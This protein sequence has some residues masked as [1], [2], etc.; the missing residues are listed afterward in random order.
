MRTKKGIV[1]SAKMNRTVAVAVTRYVVHPKYRKRYPVTKKFLADTGDLEV[2]E[3]DEVLIGETRPLS[4]RK[5]F[6][7][8]QILRSTGTGTV[9][10]EEELAAAR[11]Q[12]ESQP[13]PQPQ[14]QPA[15]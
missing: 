11:D 1:T 9:S 8:L 15:P 5:C 6:K 4:K 12:S 7:V 2:K 13:Q 3:G 10:L 14:S